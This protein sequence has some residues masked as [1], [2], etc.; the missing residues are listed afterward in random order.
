ENDL[1]KYSIDYVIKHATKDETSAADSFFKKPGTLIERD[2]KTFLQ[3]TINSWN[4]VKDITYADKKAKV[5][6]ESKENN[7]ALV[8]FEIKDDLS[9]AINLEMTVEVPGLYKQDHKARLVMD[10]SSKELIEGDSGQGGQGGMPTPPPGKSDGKVE[11]KD[12]PKSKKDESNKVKAD[13]V[14]KIDYV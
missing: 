11:D 14:S 6:S 1:V 12:N 4:M 9:K 13:K 5:I 10:A 8:E 2:G 7:S 3:T